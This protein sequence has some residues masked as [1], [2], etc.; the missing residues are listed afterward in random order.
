VSLRPYQL[1]VQNQFILLASNIFDKN[2]IH[3]YTVNFEY[4]RCGTNFITFFMIL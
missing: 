2:N 1:L 3:P 4:T